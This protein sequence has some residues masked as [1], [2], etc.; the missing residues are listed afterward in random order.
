MTAISLKK[1]NMKRWGKIHQLAMILLGYS[2]NDCEHM[3]QV[4]YFIATW[5]DMKGSLPKSNDLIACQSVIE[6]LPHTY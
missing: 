4:A 1:R 5:V 6:T 2:K 3:Y